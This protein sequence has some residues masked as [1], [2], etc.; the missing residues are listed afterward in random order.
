MSRRGNHSNLS[1]HQKPFFVFL[2][3]PT[4]KYLRFTVLNDVRA[5]SFSH[6]LLKVYI[7]SVPSENLIGRR[8]RLQCTYT[9]NRLSDYSGLI[10]SDPLEADTFVP[11]VMSHICDFLMLL[12]CADINKLSV[13]WNS[14]SA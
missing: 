3:V 6:S 10:Y 11:R 1:P 8:G 14:D 7:F 2:L 5:G 9:E 12:S 13:Q 4:V